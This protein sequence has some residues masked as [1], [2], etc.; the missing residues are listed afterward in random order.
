MGS[1]KRGAPTIRLISKR[2]NQEIHRTGDDQNGSLLTAGSARTFI[3]WL[4]SKSGNSGRL[5]AK[6]CFEPPITFTMEG[7][8]ISSVR[9]FDPEIS[10][11]DTPDR[12]PWGRQITRAGIC[13]NLV[14]PS[15]YEKTKRSYSGR[16]VCVSTN[17]KEGESN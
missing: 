16:H 15:S 6:P 17:N 1:W 11:L 2:P 12:L 4:N 3:H 8:S 13:P 7:F 10:G 14:Q 9:Y 5:S